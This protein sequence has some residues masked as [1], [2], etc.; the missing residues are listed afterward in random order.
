MKPRIYV[1]KITFEELQDWYWGVHKEIRYGEEYWGSPITNAWKWDFYT[2]L[3]QILEVFEFSEEGWSKA[4][5]VERR[6]ITP[7]L[8]NP[9]CLNEACGGCTSLKTRSISGR[10]GG[11]ATASKP[12]HM[13]KAG[14][15]SGRVWTELKR[16]SSRRNARIASSHQKDTGIQIYGPDFNYYRRKGRLNRFGIKIDGV[17]VPL[18]NL[19]ET[20]IE[21]H[22]LYGNTHSYN[23]TK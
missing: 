7:D 21:Y 9:F 23:N 10:K 14:V 11:L 5:E 16:E 19:S 18:K 1:Y 2:P 3:K 17:K 4:L 20:F 6:L 15:E 13:G 8:N 22:L 12:G